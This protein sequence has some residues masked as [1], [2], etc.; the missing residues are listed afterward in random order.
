[1]GALH[2]LANALPTGAIS[3]HFANNQQ[4]RDYATWWRRGETEFNYGLMFRMEHCLTDVQN[5]EL[6]IGVS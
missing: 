3:Q 6:Q 2:S 1:M 4:I 5:V